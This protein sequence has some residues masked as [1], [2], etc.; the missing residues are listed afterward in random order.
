VILTRT[1]LRVSF[2]G[3]GTDLP[4]FFTNNEYGSVISASIQKYV[5][6]G[7]N[8][9]FDGRIRLAYS[10]N[11][12]V[13]SIDEI[14]NDRMQEAMRKVGI[15]GGIEIFYISDVPKQLGLG[16]SSAFTVGL[17]N[18]LYRFKGQEAFP[19]RLAREACE[20]E[21]DILG[22][23]IGK[24]DQYAA[25]LGGM[26]Y[27]RFWA[28][29]TVT[30]NPLLID[31]SLIR[32]M[33]DSLLFIYLGQTHDASSILRDVNARMEDN[34]RRLT[35]MRDLA[36]GLYADLMRGN[37]DGFKDAIAKN[38]ALKKQT[39][40]RVSGGRID[41]LYERARRH[42]AE[43]GKVLGAGG[44]GFLMVCVPQDRQAAFLAAMAD[45][46]ILRFPIDHHGTQVVHAD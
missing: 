45:Q 38:W 42:G 31:E 41:D 22:N 23:P 15:T 10:R 34:E 20:I 19:E 11:E 44:G 21:I 14:E 9:R 1:P 24:Q 18:A 37:T 12:L 3:G 32:S 28:D 4:A 2:V 13:D 39:S 27:L 30:S 7:V 35:H 29:G 33:L 16:G 5:Y 46:T 26:N 43:A 17:L 40:N 25:A 6:I 8:H 36:D